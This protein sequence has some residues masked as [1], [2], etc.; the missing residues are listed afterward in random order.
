[1]VVENVVR[2]ISGCVFAVV[3]IWHGVLL[4]TLT[5]GNLVRQSKST[6]PDIAMTIN[7]GKLVCRCRCDSSG[8]IMRNLNRSRRH[9]DLNNAKHRWADVLR[10][11]SFR[12]SLDSKSLFNFQ[13]R[14]I[15]LIGLQLQHFLASLCINDGLLAERATVE[16]WLV[17]PVVGRYEIC[18]TIFMDLMQLVARK[19]NDLITTLH[20]F[21]A[22]G[23]EKIIQLCP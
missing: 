7:W 2:K 8:H 23:A 14:R 15:F 16:L 22:D 21:S 19:L 11:Y 6:R 13:V 20:R 10:L 1:M 17:I 12:Q 9:L 18:V 5:T 4:I 3:D